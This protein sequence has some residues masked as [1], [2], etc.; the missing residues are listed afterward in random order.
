MF[1]NISAFFSDASAAALTVLIKALEFAGIVFG[2]ALFLTL[3]AVCVGAGLGLM[4]WI[5]RRPLLK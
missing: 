4:D 5:T 3:F 1:A 2:G